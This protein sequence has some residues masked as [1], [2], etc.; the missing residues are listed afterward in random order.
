MSTFI[1][2]YARTRYE[3]LS[4]VRCTESRPS[5]SHLS[6]LRWAMEVSRFVPSKLREVCL[7]NPRSFS[8][9]CDGVKTI[10]K[11]RTCNNT[12][13]SPT[14][15]RVVLA[16]VAFFEHF[17][18]PCPQS[19]G[20]K[21]YL[22]GGG[23]RTRVG[24]GEMMDVEHV[25][26]GFSFAKGDYGHVV[27]FRS[28]EA[29]RTVVHEIAHA[30]YVHGNDHADVQAWATKALCAPPGVLLTE[31]FVEALTWLMLRGMMPSTSEAEELAH[32]KDLA[33]Q[34][35]GCSCDDGRTNA[36]AY[37]VGRHLLIADGG[38]KLVDFLRGS[39]ARRS[40]PSP[41]SLRRMLT[42]TDHTDVGKIMLANSQALSLCDEHKH[43]AR[44]PNSMI[45]M[46]KSVRMVLNDWGAALIE[47]DGV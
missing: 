33:V 40:D 19:K 44:Q 2:Q 24:A 13:P 4:D 25:N 34:Y 5:S 22:V 28:P 41:R 23:M 42:P 14:F 30:W 8:V 31:S 6:E 29:H 11:I 20:V 47:R 15:V 32:S 1:S 3:G 36:W 38:A 10:V 37:I 12:A 16:A 7:G 35:F 18:G 27:V 21:I 39:S 9:G 43:R 26:S 17:L 46:L 45:G